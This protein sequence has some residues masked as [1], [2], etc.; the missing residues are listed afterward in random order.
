MP[1][2]T[3]PQKFDLIHNRSLNVRI[4]VRENKKGFH[5]LLIIKAF[6]VP[7]TGFE[8][9]HLTALLP[10]NSASTNFATWASTGPTRFPVRG[11]KYTER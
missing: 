10:E 9:A 4:L 1:K 11:C 8:P 5:N 2:T 6:L 7:R 3:I